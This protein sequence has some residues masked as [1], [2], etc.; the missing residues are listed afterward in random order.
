MIV[1]LAQP[2]PVPSTLTALVGVAGRPG[3]PVGAADPRVG[4]HQ[5][6]PAGGLGEACRQRLHRFGVGDVAGVDLHLGALG[7]AGLGELLELSGAATRVREDQ[8]KSKKND[9]GA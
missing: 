5:V 4:D 8:S 9:Y 7:P 1:Q 6:H 2:E 3:Q